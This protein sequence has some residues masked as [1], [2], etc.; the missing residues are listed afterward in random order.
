[1][2]AA[3]A[4]DAAIVIDQATGQVITDVNADQPNHPASLAKMMT[5]Y[6]TFQQLQTGKLKV[7]QSLPVSAWAA[8]KAP[9]KLG[10][11]AG[12]NITVL[13]CILG[14]ITKSANDAATVAAEGI[15]GSEDGFA[16]MMNAQATRLG[17]T[18]THFANASGLPDPTDTTT[19]R[20]MVTLAMALYHDFPQYTQYFATKEFVF[21]GRLVRGHNNLMNHYPGMDGLKTGF[22]NVAGYNL[23]STAERDGHRLFGVVL[24]GRTAGIRD[25]LMARLLD[26]GFQNRETPAVLVAAAGRDSNGTA[27]RLL[28]ALSPISSAEAETVSLSPA[29]APRCHHC[30]KRKRA[31]PVAHTGCTA[32][33]KGAACPQP[34]M[35]KRKA[36]QDDE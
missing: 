27:R 28:A 14:M 15:G 6:I 33:K 34:V 16:D 7:D 25:R 19:A 32:R 18:H 22:T 9:T 36:S 30:R 26:D 35:A 31:A 10:L 12:Q 21:R 17:M 3:R 20:D 8:S 13:D 11:R 4:G 2:T 23:A 24:A 5:L 29:P 1:M